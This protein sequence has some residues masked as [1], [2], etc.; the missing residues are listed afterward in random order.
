ML[1]TCFQRRAQIAKQRAVDPAIMQNIPQ[2]PGAEELEK[3]GATVADDAGSSTQ[4]NST[5][6]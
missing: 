1:L 6:T 5:R 3:S 4:L 2:T